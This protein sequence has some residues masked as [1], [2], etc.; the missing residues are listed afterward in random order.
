MIN[1]DIASS[2]LESIPPPDLIRDRLAQL[3]TE[4]RLLRGLL[5]LS[6]SKSRCLPSACQEDL[7]GKATQR[8]VT[9]GN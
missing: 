6:E 8:E 3:F 1:S 2:P 9:L 5:R 7:G 4:A